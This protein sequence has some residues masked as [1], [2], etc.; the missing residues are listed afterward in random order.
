MYSFYQNM[1][2]LKC[3]RLSVQMVSSK[4]GG[5]MKLK[6][7]IALLGVTLVAETFS[8][9]GANHG[10]LPDHPH[11]EHQLP[12]EWV[13]ARP[14]LSGTSFGQLSVQYYGRSQRF[15]SEEKPLI[16]LRRPGRY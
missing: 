8:V 12:M 7:I 2:C 3:W 6:G 11:E 13:Q 10:I 4:V 9:N 1:N 15:A 16:T 5:E 14:S